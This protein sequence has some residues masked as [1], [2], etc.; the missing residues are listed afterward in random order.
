M[1]GWLPC[2]P[3]RLGGFGDC[4]NSS[5]L[6][7]KLMTVLGLPALLR[8]I[9]RGLVSMFVD[10]A[11]FLDPSAGAATSTVERLRRGL[12]GLCSSEGWARE[13]ARW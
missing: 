11:F 3:L 1:G 2:S 12:M 13:I 5:S 10:L 7:I 4:Y 8:S 9:T 6:S